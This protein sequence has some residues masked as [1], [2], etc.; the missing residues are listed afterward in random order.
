M[1]GRAGTF[2]RLIRLWAWGAVM[3]LAEMQL[4]SITRTEMELTE[5]DRAFLDDKGARW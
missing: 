1:M 4:A 3:D 2:R 5:A